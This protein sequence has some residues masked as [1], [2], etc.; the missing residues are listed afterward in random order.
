M[1]R[2]REG[3]NDLPCHSGTL[4]PRSRGLGLGHRSLGQSVTAYGKALCYR[5]P[6]P[7]KRWQQQHTL[8]L[9]FNLKRE[10][11]WERASVLFCVVFVYLCVCVHMWDSGTIYEGKGSAAAVV[12]WE[13]WLQAWVFPAVVSTVHVQPLYGNN[14]KYTVYCRQLITC[15][16]W[17]RS[18]KSNKWE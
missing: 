18:T 14:T 6:L 10:G 15:V 17:N 4:S 3:E 12:M 5:V 8:T 7:H 9:C 11:K 13:I 16:R 2:E 1:K